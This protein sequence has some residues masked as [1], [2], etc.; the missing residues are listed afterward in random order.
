M[1]ILP[2]EANINVVKKDKVSQTK[3]QNLKKDVSFKDLLDEKLRESHSKPSASSKVVKEKI[4]QEIVPINLLPSYEEKDI[5]QMIEEVISKWER[6]SSSLSS[7]RSSLRESFNILQEIKRDTEKLLKSELKDPRI[8][9]IIKE[10]DV[11][12]TVEEVKFNRGD[13]L[14]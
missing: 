2:N 1:K 6:Y 8:K 3:S 11:L 13:Y 5:Y 12:L 10:L 9:D 7:H 4:A 14:E